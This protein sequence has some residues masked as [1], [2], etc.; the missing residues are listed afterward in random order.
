M[1]PSSAELSWAGLAWRP[2]G[3]CRWMLLLCPDGDL[4]C[5]PGTWRCPRH[6]S[7]SLCPVW[8]LT[9]TKCASLGHHSVPLQ[10]GPWLCHSPTQART[11]CMPGDRGFACLPVAWRAGCLCNAC[12]KVSQ[13]GKSTGGPGLLSLAR[14]WHGNTSTA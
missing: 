7:C 11:L 2:P 5:A 13:Q 3:I 14:I 8:R 9:H 12:L 10:H 1:A 6:S 4:H